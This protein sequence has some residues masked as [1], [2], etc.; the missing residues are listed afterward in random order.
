MSREMRSLLGGH[1]ALA[2]MTR[3][4]AEAGALATAALSSS[5]TAAP[6]KAPLDHAASQNEKDRGV[7][8]PQT[9]GQDKAADKVDKLDNQIIAYSLYQGN[10]LLRSESRNWPVVHRRDQPNTKQFL[11]LDK[12]TLDKVFGPD[13]VVEIKFRP[14]TKNLQ[15]FLTDTWLLVKTNDPVPIL[16][17]G[18]ATRAILKITI[19]S[20]KLLPEYFAKTDEHL[21]R[22]M[23]VKDKLR[24]DVR[25]NDSDNEPA[26]KKRKGN[27]VEA[28]AEA[29][30]ATASSLAPSL[31]LPPKPA[32]TDSVAAIQA[33]LT[34]LSAF[35]AKQ[36]SDLEALRQKNETR[37]HN[38]KGLL[39][40]SIA[41]AEK[42]ANE[43]H[44][45][46]EHEQARDRV[47]QNLLMG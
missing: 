25:N 5:S 43:H 26:A 33:Y 32:P 14:L 11:L 2:A 45:A 16:A 39:L 9:G 19:K 21:N 13:N 46:M 37:E 34:A 28:K 42:R 27:D 7:E 15:G 18:R 40:E 31:P 44:K 24:D 41:Q 29:T 3:A 6:T 22:S 12:P 38:L 30:T 1:A 8:K 20:T 17:R 23:G 35:N 10:N 47:L 4:E 36:K